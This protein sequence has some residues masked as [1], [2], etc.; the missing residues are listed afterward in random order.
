MVLSFAI[1]HYR[2]TTLGKLPILSTTPS[3]TQP[4]MTLPSPLSRLRSIL[5]R[6][7]PRPIDNNK[8]A[9]LVYRIMA[10][11]RGLKGFAGFQD[12][13]AK[14]HDRHHSRHRIDILADR[15]TVSL[16]VQLPHKLVATVAAITKGTC[17]A[18]ST[19]FTRTLIMTFTETFTSMA[20]ALSDPPFLF[21][22]HIEITESRMLM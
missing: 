10:L 17:A 12:R 3:L 1:Q 8:V 18:A 11:F 16:P 13:Q 2:V 4:V 14:V 7:R 19:F 5:H 15:L 22:C 21:H 20:H 9:A 6:P